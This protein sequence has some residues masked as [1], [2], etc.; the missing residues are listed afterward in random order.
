MTEVDDVVQRCGVRTPSRARGPGRMVA[1]R[2]RA[3]WHDDQPPDLDAASE[4]AHDLAPWLPPP[5]QGDTLTLWEALASLGAVDLTVARVDEPDLDALAILREAR[6][7]GQVHEAEW[8]RQSPE[9][10]DARPWHARRRGQ[11]AAP[12]GTRGPRRQR[13]AAARVPT[14]RFWA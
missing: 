5:A 4:A 6:R 11:R 1:E 9:R 14:D 13:S 12:G 8:S 7:H 3:T 10:R 2:A